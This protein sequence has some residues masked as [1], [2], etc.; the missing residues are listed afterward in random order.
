M[1]HQRRRHHVGD[2]P[3]VNISLT[4]WHP[5]TREGCLIKPRCNL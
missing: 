4:A 1:I 3:E 2:A 5:A